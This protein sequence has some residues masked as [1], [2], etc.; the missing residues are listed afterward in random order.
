MKKYK[1]SAC[2]IALCSSFFALSQPVFADSWWGEQQHFDNIP[3]NLAIQ[4]SVHNTY[5]KT[6]VYGVDDD[7]GYRDFLSKNLASLEIDFYAEETNGVFSF[8]VGHGSGDLQNDTICLEGADKK[9]SVASC[10]ADINAWINEHHP[11]YP[12]TLFLDLKN[13]GNYN[14]YTYQALE[15]TFTKVFTGDTLFT[16]STLIQGKDRDYVSPRER[17]DKIGWPTMAEM[18]GKVIV[19]I[20]TGND[21]LTK[22][23][24]GGYHEN[25]WQDTRFF[26]TPTPCE[27]GEGNIDSDN[28]KLSRFPGQV[29]SVNQK[30]QYSTAKAMGARAFSNGFS[31][32]N[33]DIDDECNSSSGDL[34]TNDFQSAVNEFFAGHYAADPRTG[35]RNNNYPVSCGIPLLE[36]AELSAG[37]NAELALGTRLVST[38]G[39]ELDAMA[40]GQSGPHY[41]KIKSVEQGLCLNEASVKAGAQITMRSCE[42]TDTRIRIEKVDSGRHW[43]TAD[44]TLML[45]VELKDDDTDVLMELQDFKAGQAIEWESLPKSGGQTSWYLVNMPDG[46][47]RILSKYT[48]LCLRTHYNDYTKVDACNGYDSSEWKITRWD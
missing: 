24:Q 47:Y 40:S 13:G 43:Q 37:E 8:N 7:S 32:R 15:Q 29:V 31:L 17:V 33:W 23:A 48:G 19:F 25:N 46:N 3:Y 6:D 21:E 26:V 39:D 41:F 10:L 16:P 36:Q 14:Q 20:A 4:F 27:S 42:D 5:D 22:Y 34:S 11:D 30:H 44:G 35:E 2:A 9:T 38:L 1:K 12:I 28:C 18:A 45:E